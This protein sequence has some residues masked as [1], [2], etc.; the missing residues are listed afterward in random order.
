MKR[1][2]N[3]LILFLLP[4]LAMAQNPGNDDFF[5]NIGKIYVVVAVIVILFIG[6]VFFLFFP[7][8]IRAFLVTS[9]SIAIGIPCFFALRVSG[10]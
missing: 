9:D 3:T 1:I 8:I 6:I 2:Y 5:T 4:F 7:M 10:F